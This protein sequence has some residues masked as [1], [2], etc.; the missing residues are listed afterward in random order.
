MRIGL[1]VLLMLLFAFSR[2]PGLMP[3]NFSAVYALVFCGGVFLPRKLSWWLPLVTLLITD[4]FLNI[5]YRRLYAGNPGGFEAEIQ[6]I[7]P[8]LLA[9]YVS[10]A[11][12]IWLGSRFRASAHWLKLLGGGLLGAVIFYLLSNTASW[13]QLPGYAKTLAG[14]W[15]ALTTGLPGLPPTW[16]FLLKSLLSTGLFTGLFVGAMKLAVREAEAP[17]PANDEEV[18]EPETLPPEESKANRLATKGTP[19]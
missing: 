19:G 16:M 1:P 15:Q 8:Y 6:F 11:L 2:W 13:L 17:E 14:W 18:T 10:Y 3:D 9:N 12:L 5:Y 7:N 4:V